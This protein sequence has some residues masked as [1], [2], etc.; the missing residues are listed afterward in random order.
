MNQIPKYDFKKKNERPLEFEILDL[1]KLI[2]SN[3]HLAGKPHRLDFY[4]LI[5]ISKGTGIHTV[6]FKHANFKRHFLIPVAKDQVQQFHIDFKIEGYLILFTSEFLIREKINYRYLYDFIIFNS[7]L[8][9]VGLQCDTETTHLIEM[10]AKAYFNEEEFEQEKILR[11]F[12][13]IILIKLEQTKRNLSRTHNDSDLNLTMRFN[14]VLDKNISYKT[15]VSDIC[16]I[17]GINS[18]KLNAALKLTSNKT[19]KAY[20]DERVIL[21]IKRLLSYS[22]FSIK[23]IAYNIGFE[24]PT[25]LTKFFKKHTNFLPQDFRDMHN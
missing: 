24:E 11:N 20:L 3:H 2:K 9:P 8:S 19:A 10:L 13:K 23:E 18:K 1:K 4:Q 22:Q 5:F 17:L 15:K 21:E 14:R 7:Q 12:L 16:E 25:N 6:D